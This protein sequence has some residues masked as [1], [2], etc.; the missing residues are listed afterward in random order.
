MDGKVIVLGILGA[1][2]ALGVAGVA[3]WNASRDRTTA[4]S[5]QSESAAAA[6]ATQ[7]VQTLKATPWSDEGQRQPIAETTARGGLSLGDAIKRTEPSVVRLNTFAKSGQPLGFGTGFVV[8][9][10]GWVATNYHVIRTAARALAL[11]RDGTSVEVEGLVAEDEGA[12][13]A[14][15]ALKKEGLQKAGARPRP[16]ELHAP[17]PATGESV[18]AMGHPQGLTFTVTTGSVGALRRTA[19]LPPELPGPSDANADTLWV[20]SDAAI[21]G[22]SSGGPLCDSQGRVIGVNSWLAVRQN[23]AF[24]VH[25]GHLQGLIKSAADKSATDKLARLPG[26]RPVAELDNPLATVEPRV[27]LMWQEFV[28][29]E[30]EFGL[31]LRRARTEAEQNELFKTQSPRPKYADRFLRIADSERK[32]AAA[33]QSLFLAC[34]MHY[35]GMDGTYLERA[36]ERLTEDHLTDRGVYHIFAHLAGSQHAAA[37]VFLTKAIDQSPHRHV[38][39]AAC[40]VLAHWLIAEGK[41]DKGPALRLLERCDKDFG[42]VKLDAG[43]LGDLAR[44]D[45]MKARYFSVGATPPDIEGKDA[46]GKPLKLSEFRGKVVLLDFF[47]DWCP[48]CVAMYPHE[49]KLVKKFAGR[50]FALLGINSDSFDTLRQV[51]GS[52]KVSWRCWPD[53]PNGPVAQRWQIDS[54]PTLFLL[55]GQGVIRQIFEGRPQPESQ[56][57]EAIEKLVAEAEKAAAKE[58]TAA[59]EKADAP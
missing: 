47:A 46:E 51:I 10:R 2:L 20:Q 39:G 36:L 23:F 12:D 49:Q 4:S 3:L 25:V 6:G 5:S 52:G 55:D 48:H 37:K 24:A 50:P 9:E 59:K 57:D 38:Q 13:L 28:R 16:L 44:R 42:D 7:P 17:Q 15:V 18:F 11:F 27:Q 31:Q 40:Y 58:K 34:Q 26:D 22:G 35:P 29:A 43:R 14:I 30:Q 53:G 45:G 1:A 56:L 33:V 32:T 54:F 41:P 21:A 8:D 19:D